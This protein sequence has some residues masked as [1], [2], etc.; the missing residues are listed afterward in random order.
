MSLAERLREQRKITVRVDNA[1]FYARRATI[2]EF[3]RYSID[4]TLD[5]EVARLHVTGW[6]GVKECDLI[7]DGSKEVIPFDREAFIEAIGDKPEWFNAIAKQ[8][9]DEAIKR[10]TSKAENEKK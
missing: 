7:D 10:L 3:S 6:D 5:A 2:E 4:R 8:V 1:T 9:L